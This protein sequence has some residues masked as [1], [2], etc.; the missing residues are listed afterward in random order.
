[1]FVPLDLREGLVSFS[2]SKMVNFENPIIV[3]SGMDIGYGRRKYKLSVFTFHVSTLC[4]LLYY[5]TTT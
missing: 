1:M 3:A 4:I 5:S 2:T